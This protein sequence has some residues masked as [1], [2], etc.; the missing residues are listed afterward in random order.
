MSSAPWLSIVVPAYNAENYLEECVSSVNLVAHPEVEVLLVDDGSTDSTPRICNELASYYDNLKVIHR[1]NGGL[2][3]ARNTGCAHAKGDWI[4]FVDSDDIIAPYALDVIKSAARDTNCDAI[5]IQFLK[6]SDGEKPAWPDAGVSDSRITL[7][8][9]EYLREIYRGR[10]QHY[11]CSFLFQRG[12]LIGGSAESF[13]FSCCKGTRADWP[14]HEGYSLYEDVVSMEEILRRIDCVYV[15]QAQ[16][17]GYR[18]VASSMTHKPNNDAAESGL[19][20]VLDL[21][22]Y[23]ALGEV[24]GKLC[25]EISLL[26]NSYK[27]VEWGDSFSDALRSKYR[28]EIERRVRKVGLTHLGFDRL[29]RFFLLKTGLLDFIFKRRYG[30]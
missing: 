1:E 27:L 2:P 9:N 18:Q 28:C 21:S 7:T 6:Y 16:C 10:G 11:I 25:L 4:W 15:L 26:F 19:R 20:A 14:F 13:S 24:R 23:D 22:K 12:A 30:R 5:Q 17:Y 29:S 3:S 8:S